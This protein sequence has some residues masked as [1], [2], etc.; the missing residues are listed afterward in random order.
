MSLGKSLFTAGGQT[1]LWDGQNDPMPVAPA[2]DGLSWYMSDEAFAYSTGGGVHAYRRS[3][4]A[5]RLVLSRASF[6]TAAD[7]MP[8]MRSDNLPDHLFFIDKSNG[9]ADTLGAAVGDG[10]GRRVLAS[11]PGRRIVW[12]GGV[13][14]DNRVLTFAL[15]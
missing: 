12:S 11:E 1:W 6:V 8:S 14:W 15:V 4:P 2:A 10:T 5:D 7:D 13:S 9:R 3:P